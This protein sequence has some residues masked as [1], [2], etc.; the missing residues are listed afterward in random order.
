MVRFQPPSVVQD[1][2]DSLYDDHDNRARR[3]PAP[4]K[5]RFAA[6]M[7]DDSESDE[8]FDD[9]QDRMY[10]E[11]DIIQ[12]EE[13][14]DEDAA[15]DDVALQPVDDND[16]AFTD[17]RIPD[18]N[19]DVDGAVDN[20]KSVMHIPL[21]TI[22]DSPL[23]Q[24]PILSRPARIDTDKFALFDIARA[25]A[26]TTSASLSSTAVSSVATRT[27]RQSY[28]A[29]ASINGAWA[30]PQGTRV[31]LTR[32]HGH[33]VSSSSAAAIPRI[34]SRDEQLRSEWCIRSLR[35]HM[36]FI[37]AKEQRSSTFPP[38]TP[39]RSDLLRLADA[40]IQVIDTMLEANKPT[41]P[42]SD[43]SSPYTFYSQLQHARSVFELAKA[44]FAPEFG[45]QSLST[46][47]SAKTTSNVTQSPYAER[48]ARTQA[49]S[50][51]LETQVAAE[52]RAELSTYSNPL[53]TIFTHLS[54]HDIVPATL[55]AAQNKDLRLST[56]IPHLSVPSQTFHNDIAAQ[57]RQ[58]QR[59]DC[60]PTY[61][62]HR[63]R[64]VYSLCSGNISVRPNMS[65][66]RCFGQALWYGRSRLVDGAVSEYQAAVN[67]GKAR[68][69]HAPYQVRGLSKSTTQ[70]NRA[71]RDDDD[72]DDEQV[73]QPQQQQVTASE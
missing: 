1:D 40:Y 20:D 5:N 59:L 18:D 56:I 73:Q 37:N 58:W 4:A 42:S 72:D 65:W 47:L 23:T 13:E 53:D 34:S 30:Y 25:L 6:P 38:L 67:H 2:D 66:L 29:S 43:S 12:D 62:S 3:R 57:L 33:L 48:Y 8:E 7:S 11:H 39:A 27:N 70:S 54:G 49:V 28:R 71:I 35:V 61:I 52:V 69:P 60:W 41:P 63:E 36:D 24:P 21:M 17:R 19:D 64:E 31:V 50:N 68:P 32:A 9:E 51:W 14:E 46:F 55:T 10:D 26:N 45:A 16:A 44:L 15:V 22:D